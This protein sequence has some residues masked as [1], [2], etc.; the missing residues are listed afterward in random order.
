MKLPIIP[1][2]KS[3]HIVYGASIAFVVYVL[4][5]S[6]HRFLIVEI[7]YTTMLLLSDTSVLFFAVFKE[8]RDYILNLL[9]RGTHG[10]E[11]N[12]I[13]ATI[14]GGSLVLLPLHL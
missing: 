12:D 2:D 7:D 14:Y 9:A 10:V 3:L 6:V 1:W 8:V 4:L 11:L 5:H 13:L